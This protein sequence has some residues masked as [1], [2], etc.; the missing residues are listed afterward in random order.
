[1]KEEICR[2]IAE[3]DG[4]IQDFIN[5]LE[6]AKK[7]GATHYRYKLTQ[8]RGEDLHDIILEKEITKEEMKQREIQQ[9][10]ARLKTLKDL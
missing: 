3:G 2:G 10:E 8:D 5:W 7:K 9:L 1:M 4:L 6:K